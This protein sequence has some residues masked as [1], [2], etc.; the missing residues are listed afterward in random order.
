MARSSEGSP[1][2]DRNHEGGGSWIN[3]LMFGEYE[4]NLTLT[5]VLISLCVRVSL[6][7]PTSVVADPVYQS[8]KPVAYHGDGCCHHGNQ[9][10]RSNPLSTC[11]LDLVG[12][13]QVLAGRELADSGS[14][15]VFSAG[16]RVCQA[17]HL[18]PS[19]PPP[20]VSSLRA[21]KSDSDSDG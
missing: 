1:E 18:H 3:P 15:K 12:L 10:S 13:G 14:E 16:I 7:T 20:S 8:R 11:W 6:R 17:R 5:M 4:L 19:T 21:L 2:S 9:G